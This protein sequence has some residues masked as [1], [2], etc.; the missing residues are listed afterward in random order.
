M[1]MWA[2]THNTLGHVCATQSIRVL[3]FIRV[4]LRSMSCVIHD[5]VQLSVTVPLLAFKIPEAEERR[6]ARGDLKRGRNAF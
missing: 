4:H 1:F 3:V 5:E 6:R 2:H